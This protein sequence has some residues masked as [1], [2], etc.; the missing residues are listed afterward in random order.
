[1]Q[2]LNILHFLVLYVLYMTSHFLSFFT[3]FSCQKTQERATELA[4][5]RP[6]TL[7]IV[8]EK[9]CSHSLTC[10]LIVYKDYLCW[11]DLLY[12]YVNTF[13]HRLCWSF[14]RKIWRQTILVKI[15]ISS[16]SLLTCSLPQHI[17]R[18]HIIHDVSET[19]LF[20]GRFQSMTSAFITR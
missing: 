12:R 19:G 10:F 13:V 9:H 15:L 18:Y 14:H 5:W 2:I 6:K 3:F 16:V 1:M 4:C 11:M 17:Y 8:S 7:R 20:W